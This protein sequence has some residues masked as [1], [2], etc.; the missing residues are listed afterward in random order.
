MDAVPYILFLAGLVFIIKG[1][2]LF[3]D[4]A[5]WV[6]QT[7]G[8][9][10]VFIGATI[11]SL[12]TTIPET[13]VSILSSINNQPSMAIGNA[14]GSIIC[15]T[16]LILGLY[17]LIK[18]TRINTRIFYFK[19]LLLLFYMVVIWFL[20]KN[21]VIG[22]LSVSILILL[23]FI[24][25]IFNLMIAGYK[26][27]HK[28]SVAPSIFIKRCYLTFLIQFIFGAVLILLGSNLLLKY[29]VVIAKEWGVPEAVISLTLISFGTSLPELITAI[30]SLTKGHVS[31]G[32]G[33]ILGANILNVT[34]V[35]GLSGCFRALSVP[36]QTYYL[37]IPV[38]FALNF[39]LV[40]PTIFTK[41]INRI[42]SALLLTGYFAYIIML[43]C[44]W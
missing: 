14:I 35:I 38:A 37:D 12:A 20:S 32:I 19:G 16:G 42:Q 29:G 39:I 28:T 8:L 9:P 5:T 30:S 4:A 31:I 17:C 41:R 23:L 18:P 1:G 43:F 26:K 36:A 27:S 6:A 15:N 11:V 21:K 33:N 22:P 25:M 40:V 34:M 44:I 24:Y 10:E 2:D 13:T 3:V 7:T